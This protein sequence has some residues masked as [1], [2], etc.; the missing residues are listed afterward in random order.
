MGTHFTIGKINWNNCGILRNSER[1]SQPSHS[2]VS[3]RTICIVWAAAVNNECHVGHH[4]HQ[5]VSPS[6]VIGSSSCIPFF[7]WLKIV[8]LTIIWG[9][10]HHW[11]P[12]L[13]ENNS[14]WFFQS[15]SFYVKKV[16]EHNLEI[17]IKVLL[18][19]PPGLAP[20][21]I[22]H[23]DPIYFFSISHFCSFIKA[24]TLPH[25]SPDPWFLI[26]WWHH[27]Q[28]WFLNS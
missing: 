7:S 19:G 18:C 3:C 27:L 16:Q 2:L 17:R 23:V 9:S 22:L 14:F 24:V 5:Q 4:F 8:V 28:L 1:I 26:G 10:I 6:C 11:P 20:H 21:Q 25:L 15:G 12:F 13:P